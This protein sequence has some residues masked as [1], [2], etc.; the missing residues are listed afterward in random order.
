LDRRAHFTARTSS[1][2]F[3]RHCVWIGLCPLPKPIPWL[4]IDLQSHG[5]ASRS[6]AGFPN[7]DV[8]IW[9]FIQPARQGDIDALILTDNDF[10]A[11]NPWPNGSDIYITYQ[12]AQAR[13]LA[14]MS[15]VPPPSTFVSEGLNKHAVFFGCDDKS[16]LTLC[17]FAKRQLH[18]R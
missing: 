4:F 18:L 5:T 14:R 7:Q 11:A 1:T 12:Q 3:R 17:I 2:E 16:M 13:G 9:P 15:E 8:P 10:D 6:T